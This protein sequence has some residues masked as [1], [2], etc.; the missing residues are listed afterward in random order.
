[1][2][3]TIKKP[4]FNADNAEAYFTLLCTYYR[5][6][7]NR[8]FKRDNEGRHASEAVYS[9]ESQKLLGMELAMREVLDY[10]S[11]YDFPA[12][13]ISVKDR[14]PEEHKDAHDELI[15]YLCYMP[16]YGI[17]IANYVKPAGVWVCMGIPTKVTHWM[18]LPDP[19]ED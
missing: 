9:A 17:D 19:P 6:E 12:G 5:D 14:L 18:P 2:S 11:D 16:G 7:K 4:L 13:W 3:D 15:N 1:M 10:F 8:I